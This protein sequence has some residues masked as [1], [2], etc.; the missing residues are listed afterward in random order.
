MFM[1]RFI[2]RAQE[3]EYLNKEY[4]KKG[5]KFV[6]QYGRRRIGKTELIKEFIKNKPNIYFLADKRGIA[7]NVERF[8]LQVEETLGIPP[9]RA[10]AFEDIFKE[11]AKQNKR[12]VI[13]IDE[14]TY[15]IEVDPSII[16]VFQL[17]CDEI[18]KNK[19]IFL[20]ISGSYVSMM[21]TEVLS[22]KSPLYGRR[23]GQIELKKFDIANA[24][25]F[26]PQYN[27]E[28]DIESYSILDTIPGYL[29]FFDSSLSIFENIK[30]TFLNKEHPLYLEPEI[31]MKEELKEPTNYFNIIEAIANGNTRLTDIANKSNVPF[32][33]MPKYLKI[34]QKLDFVLK[35]HPVTE[36]KIISKKSLYY[37]SDN[38]FRFWFRFILPNKSAVEKEDLELV[39]GKIKSKFNAFTGIG[40]E[41]FSKL[42]IENLNLQSKLPFHFTKIGKQWGKAKEKNAYEIDIVALNEQTKEIL[43]AECKWQSNVNAK[44]VLEELK[45]KVKFVEWNNEKRKE[46][47]ALFAKSFREKIK[48]KNILLFDLK[49]IE[50]VLRK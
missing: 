34:L 40:F 48:D 46:Y 19:D 17:I 9:L 36:K 45:E 41:R 35:E 27:I 1:N 33:D 24:I 43:F 26:L 3:L 49:D 44:K 13:V 30:E 12:Y 32:K 47:Y 6:V 28:Q 29:R 11:L 39:L 31:L 42:C 2:D 22:Y 5:F 18:L 23:T 16:S 10:N 15:L 50:N 8:R 4:S 38:L 37:L 7:K 14:F 25:K 21:E 20:I